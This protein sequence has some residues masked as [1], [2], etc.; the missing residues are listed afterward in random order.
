MG[1]HGGS[2]PSSGTKRFFY[3]SMTSVKSSK[4]NA[5]P[6]N[7]QGTR[8]ITM[9]NWHGDNGGCYLR[10]DINGTSFPV[11]QANPLLGPNDLDL[12]ATGDVRYFDAGWSRMH[13]VHVV[14]TISEKHARDIADAFVA[15]CTDLTFDIDLG[16]GKWYDA[17]GMLVWNMGIEAIAF[18]GMGAFA[19]RLDKILPTEVRNKLTD[20]VADLDW[21][22]RQPATVYWCSNDTIEARIEQLC[23]LADKFGFEMA[24]VKVRND[25]NGD[26]PAHEPGTS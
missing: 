17:S 3:D 8:K 14:R 23:Q 26:S 1:D 11:N 19:Q 7:K 10:V 25:E 2:P 22:D 12:C 15:R 20:K 24:M 21:A 9:G 6:G 4:R 16:N 18:V 5:G 13:K